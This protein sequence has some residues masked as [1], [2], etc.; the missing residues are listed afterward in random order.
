MGNEAS[1]E[2]AQERPPSP[3]YQP[4][5]LPER[6][7]TLAELRAYDGTKPSTDHFNQ[8]PIY[9]A[10]NFVVF[11]VTAGKKFYGPGTLRIFAFA[12]PSDLHFVIVFVCMTSRTCDFYNSGAGYNCFAGRDASRGLAQMEFKASIMALFSALLIIRRLMHGIH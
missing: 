10:V 6:D 8:C 3:A 4:P 7:F 9:L 5:D 1:A 12:F 11:D 2:E